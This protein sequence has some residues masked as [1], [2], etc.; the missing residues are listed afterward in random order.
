[1]SLE[2]D[3]VLSNNENYSKR[4]RMFNA[5]VMIVVCPTFLLMA[6]W[7]LSAF[8]VCQSLMGSTSVGKFDSEIKLS[9]L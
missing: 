1:M 5:L 9:G 7:L 2:S 8:N 6:L 4:S 3:T